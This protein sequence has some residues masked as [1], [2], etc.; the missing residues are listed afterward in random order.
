MTKETNVTKMPVLRPKQVI[1]LSLKHSKIQATFDR[2]VM[3]D[4]WVQSS[5]GNV[6]LI[7]F[8]TQLHISFVHDLQVFSGLAKVMSI[9]PREERVIL[10]QPTRLKARPMRKYFR[11]KARL[12]AAIVTM[13]STDETSNYMQRD[14]GCL[15]DLSE[16][17]ALLGSNNPLPMA[18]RKVMLLFSLDASDPYN[19]GLQVYIPARIVRNAAEVKDR[20]FGYYYG[21]EFDNVVPTFHVMLLHYIE[22]NGSNAK[23]FAKAH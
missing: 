20:D 8:A 14:D 6:A 9:S 10:S 12:P 4:W 16:A 1:T 23:R 21:L 22:L 17:G 13:S 7:E 18:P 2:N 3:G 19:H 11:V 5:A 15:L